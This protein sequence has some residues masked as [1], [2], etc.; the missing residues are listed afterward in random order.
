MTSSG[1]FCL[2]ILI[3]STLLPYGGADHLPLVIN[4]WSVID[5][6][7]AGEYQSINF[8]MTQIIPCAPAASAITGGKS[9]L[10]AIVLGCSEAEKNTSYDTIGYGG[11]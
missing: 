8:G 4:T 2:S 10:D 3:C 6:N 1:F 11:R 7:S 9:F 5:A